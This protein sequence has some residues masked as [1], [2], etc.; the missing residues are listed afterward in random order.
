[1]A[2]RCPCCIEVEGQESGF[3]LAQI[4]SFQTW[5][6]RLG[7]P[8][9]WSNG[10]TL[11]EKIIVVLHCSMT[12]SFLSIRIYDIFSHKIRLYSPL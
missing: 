9:G 7:F 1:M 3:E 2:P 4:V 8:E 11:L 10:D 12:I 6:N 5:T